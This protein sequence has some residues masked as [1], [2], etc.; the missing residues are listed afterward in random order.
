[1]CLKS[2]AKCVGKHQQHATFGEGVILAIDGVSLLIY[3]KN[4]PLK[5]KTRK[6]QTL[7]RF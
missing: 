4:T 7:F 2:F 1:M 3:F 5:R 6:R